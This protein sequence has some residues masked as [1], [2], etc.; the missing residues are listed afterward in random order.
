MSAVNWPV[1]PSGIPEEPPFPASCEDEAGGGGGGGGGEVLS[2][3]AELSVAELSEVVVEASR[4]KE[5]VESVEPELSPS[6]PLPLPLLVSVLSLLSEGDR[7]VE[8][9]GSDGDVESFVQL[10]FDVRLEKSVLFM[11]SIRLGRSLG[12]T[13][14]VVVVFVASV[15]FETAEPSETAVEFEEDNATHAGGGVGTSLKMNELCFMIRSKLECYSATY[16]ESRL[17]RLIGLA[18]EIVASA[19][20]EITP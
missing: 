18:D 19:S 4:G 16:D 9:V 6:L 15:T 7:S 8:L 10:K 2:G 5:L 20:N 11:P 14:H 13:R 12:E 3:G 17:A 1:E